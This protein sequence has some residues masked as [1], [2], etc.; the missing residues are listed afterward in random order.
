MASPEPL[1]AHP[2][3]LNSTSECSKAMLEF[4]FSFSGEKEG[5]SVRG[6]AL[7]PC[8]FPKGQ[9]LKEGHQTKP[10]G[11]LGVTTHRS[12]VEFSCCLSL[13]MT[14]WM[15]SMRNS[16]LRWSLKSRLSCKGQGWAQHSK[17]LRKFPEI[18][19][20]QAHPR[21]PLCPV[22]TTPAP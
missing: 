12:R 7:E 20:P 22:L 2:P 18:K 10:P 3:Q 21:A 19:A 9:D 13:S 4:F 11:V 5:I 8:D 16:Y 6:V 14:G 17:V 15:P 1:M